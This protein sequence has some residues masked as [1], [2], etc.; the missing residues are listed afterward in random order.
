MAALLQQPSLPLW[1]KG[2]VVQEEKGPKLVAQEIAPLES[3][4]ERLPEKLDLRLQALSVTQEQLLKLKEILSRHAG[5]VPA[6]LH[7]LQPQK[8]TTLA[9]P[10]EL[11]LSPSPQ[12]T[13]EVNRLF[14]YPALSL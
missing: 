14:G 12:L 5:P 7:F 3:M 6:F 10:K 8:D 2:H 11:S 13:S 1:L 4:L 9:L